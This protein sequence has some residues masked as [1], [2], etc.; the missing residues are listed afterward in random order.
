MPST[1][2]KVFPHSLY[3]SL[4]EIIIRFVGYSTS[5]E[6]ILHNSLRLMD[7]CFRGAN[8]NVG[9]DSHAEETKI[10][11]EPIESARII[12]VKLLVSGAVKDSG[13][14]LFPFVCAHINLKFS[15]KPLFNTRVHLIF[16]KNLR[17]YIAH[18]F[19][20]IGNKKYDF[21]SNSEWRLDQESR[22][23]VDEQITYFCMNGTENEML[24]RIEIESYYRLSSHRILLLLISP[25]VLGIPIIALW[26][27]PY[28]SFLAK[29][30]LT[31]SIIPL[32]F[33]TWTSASAYMR[34]I[35]CFESAFYAILILTWGFYILLLQSFGL[36]IYLIVFIACT[37]LIM[38]YF[39]LEIFLR[40]RQRPIV[41]EKKT[42]IIW[43][44]GFRKICGWFYKILD[45]I[46]KML[47]NHDLLIEK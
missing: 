15:I 7:I 30:S 41:E 18:S 8:V 12:T 16:P 45:T 32:I 13:W 47:E 5:I 10:S 28:L 20:S 24:T 34:D 38:L 2:I 14:N 25:Y 37:Y 43:L 33:Y 6:L 44:D 1:F 35:I 21:K 19:I 11:L 23:L 3:T 29:I 36:S 17:G 26:V 31:L 27:F 40:F 22:G 46:S 42:G 4:T 39:I 9:H